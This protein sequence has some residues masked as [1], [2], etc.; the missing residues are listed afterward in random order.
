MTFVN[1]SSV[2]R[3]AVRA[4]DTT[5]RRGSAVVARV[6]PAIVALIDPHPR[7]GK[8]VRIVV[9]VGACG[10]IVRSNLRLSFHDAVL[11]SNDVPNSEHRNYCVTVNSLSP[12][13]KVETL[14]SVTR[15]P[16][17]FKAKNGSRTLTPYATLSSENRGSK[18]NQRQPIEPVT[19]HFSALDP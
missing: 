14:C 11:N 13:T 8:T 17:F 3:I 15:I 6:L 18:I 4:T 19:H 10:H 2:F 9:A 1:L 5:A 7:A 12:I 16:V